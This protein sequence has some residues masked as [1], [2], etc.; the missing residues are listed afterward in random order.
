MDDHLVNLHANVYLKREFRCTFF[1]PPFLRFVL[2]ISS[3]L[4][5]FTMQAPLTE[6][7]VLKQQA[8]AKIRSRAEEILLEQQD[9]AK[10]MNR[11]INYSKCVTIR[12]AQLA[13]RKY[14]MMEEE[15]ENRRLDTLM[16][17]ERLK[18]L[19]IYEE[20]ELQRKDERLK[21]AQV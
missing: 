16:E 21:G 3:M 5:R 9:E 11:M 14:M 18:A 8:D 13:E 19:R 10:A 20:R 6:T 15:E 7:E 4:H 12:D 2:V 1:T 17:T